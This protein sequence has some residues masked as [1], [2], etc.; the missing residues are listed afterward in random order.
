[1]VPVPA[2]SL[3]DPHVKHHITSAKLLK[4]NPSAVPVANPPTSL[5]DLLERL[6][7]R[8]V[9]G[10]EAINTV[11]SFIHANGIDANDAD[12]GDGL[13]LKEVFAR[14]LDKNLKAGVAGKTL[15]AVRWRTDVVKKEAQTRRADQ[16]VSPRREASLLTSSNASSGDTTSA[17]ATSEA[18][19]VSPRTSPDV[20]LPPTRLPHFSC[21]LGKTVLRKD[22]DRVLSIPSTSP[23]STTNG[24]PKWLASRKLDGVRMIVVID[25]YIPG[26]NDR[27]S[28]GVQVRDLWTL[29]RSGKEYTSLDI[30][31][32]Q[33]RETLSGC[34]GLSEILKH[35]PR[36]P[37]SNGSSGTIQRLV[38]DGELCHLIDD[39]TTAHPIEDFTQVVSMVR[40]K[41][42]TMPRPTMFL[43][44]VIPWSVFVDGTGKNGDGSA[45]GYKA[46]ADRV[47]DCEAVVERVD[48]Q[49]REMGAE[50]VLKKLEQRAV[51]SIQEVEEMIGIAAERGWEGLVIRRGD[52]PYE[53]KRRWALI[54][55]FLTDSD[56]HGTARTSSNTKNGKTGNMSS[57]ERT[58][59]RCDYQSMG[60]T[61][62]GKHWPLSG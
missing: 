10:T 21:A 16:D 47:R 39:P 20:L 3:Y 13:S 34:S 31:K 15:A 48:K 11:T 60:Y 62:S 32:R 30:L 18:S 12:E 17:Q 43:L 51:G 38:L 37:T 26:S 4:A 42:F 22:L 27:G 35:E 7:S 36:Y 5:S 50:C 56:S 1:M 40:R 58:R 46:F 14:V 45:K 55:C 23:S 29:S 54:V 8:Q 44:D 49:S 28:K 9:T 61:P 25:V 19:P 33:L 52:M 24:H 59:P 2:S 53:G 6:S 41:G 57:L